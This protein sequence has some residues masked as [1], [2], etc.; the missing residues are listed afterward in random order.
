[1]KDYLS[2]TKEQLQA[3]QK[4]LYFRYEEYQAKGLKLDMSRG[5]PCLEQLDLSADLLQPCNYIDDSGVDSRNYGILAGMP[6]ARRFFAELMGVD[7]EEVIVGGNASLSLMYYLIDLG[8]RVGF[9]DSK[10]P[11]RFDEKIKFL[12]PVPGYDRHFAITEYFGF[13]M[14][15]IPMTEDGPDMDMVEKLVTS[16]ESIKGIWC[17]PLYSNPDGF[18][19]SDDTV[20]RLASMPTAAKDFKIIWD[21]AYCVH[22]LTDEVCST[23]NILQEC[24]KVGTENR[25]ILLCSTSKITFPGAGVAAMAG[26]RC[27]VDY[28]LKN[29]GPMAI[30][31]L[32][33]I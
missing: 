8:W 28:I 21:D 23:L 18:I 7:A 17:V 10:R 11:W 27:N 13:E 2:M 3:E 9:P 6:D 5:K 26:S 25:P 32:I 16:D 14:L 31:S 15:S 12:C 22:H 33:H 1:M 24:K 29:M 20:R 4:E 19:Y 30:L